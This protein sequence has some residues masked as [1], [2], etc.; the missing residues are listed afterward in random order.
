MKESL[1]I[2]RLLHSNLAARNPCGTID[3]EKLQFPL[4]EQHFNDEY[5]FIHSSR[6]AAAEIQT[7]KSCPHEIPSSKS[8][9]TQKNQLGSDF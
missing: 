3:Q 8:C 9:S 1:L 5:A 6:P 4:V 7:F 2:I